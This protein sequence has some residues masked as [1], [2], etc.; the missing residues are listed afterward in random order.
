MTLLANGPTLTVNR[1]VDSVPRQTTS[2]PSSSPFN[3][4]G[5]PD[6]VDREVEGA[7]FAVTQGEDIVSFASTQRSE[8]ILT[9]ARAEQARQA[10]ATQQAKTDRAEEAK[11]SREAQE[12][13]I[14][15]A[16]E[17]DEEALLQEQQRLQR[18]TEELNGK[19]NDSL[20]L[21]FEKDQETG[22]DVFK[23]IE[24]ETG[25]V[26]RQVPSEE[27]LEFMRKFRSFSGLLFSEQ[28]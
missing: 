8:D 15:K 24:R 9:F 12:L 17:D 25:D 26:V 16:R 18:I 11:Q 1:A 7:A 13:S 21:R 20:R 23:L 14:K 2:L 22:V 28:A 27:V 19:L 4:A 6:A 3:S 5:H 10:T